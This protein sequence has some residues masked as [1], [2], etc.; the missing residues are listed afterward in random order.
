MQSCYHYK[1]LCWTEYYFFIQCMDY[2]WQSSR[3]NLSLQLSL[4]TPLLNLHNPQSCKAHPKECNTSYDGTKYLLS[5]LHV[6]QTV[7]WHWSDRPA[8][9]TS[10]EVLKH[11]SLLPPTYLHFKNNPLVFNI[12]WSSEKLKIHWLIVWTDYKSTN[13]RVI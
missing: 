1:L 7:V 10:F 12:Y 13:Q 3:T 11:H 9:R 4:H 5:S 8:R 2:S 6:S